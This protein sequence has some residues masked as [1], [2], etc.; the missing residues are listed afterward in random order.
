MGKIVMHTHTDHLSSGR[1]HL[2]LTGVASLA[3]CLVGI[4][5][6]V[7]VLGIS[8]T[9]CL[10]SCESL[11]SARWS[12]GQ[13]RICEKCMESMGCSYQALCESNH[14]A[15]DVC[16]FQNSCRNV[17]KGNIFYVCGEDGSDDT[18]LSTDPG[19]TP[20]IGYVVLTVMAFTSAGLAIVSPFCAGY[21]TRMS[22]LARTTELD[23]DLDLDAE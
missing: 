20:A 17:P 13:P 22:K 8:S 12:S 4:L 16:C 7:G 1:L 9:S 23:I 2:P 14:F 10:V 21:G 18:G 5:N 3:F 19:C 11:C 15:D 6:L